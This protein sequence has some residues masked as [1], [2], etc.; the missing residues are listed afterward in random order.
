MPDSEVQKV[1]TG[2]GSA[3][4]VLV[5]DPKEIAVE[6]YCNAQFRMARGLSGDELSDWFD[7]ESRV[8]RRNRLMATLGVK[9]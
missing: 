4:Q 1:Q 6:A 8:N 9:R 2:T 5:A 3:T 7:G